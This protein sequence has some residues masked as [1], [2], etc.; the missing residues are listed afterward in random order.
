MSRDVSSESVY[1]LTDLCRRRW[2]IPI[3]G[4]LLLR[5]AGAE[6]YEI[7][8]CYADGVFH[9]VVIHKT[10][11]NGPDG[12]I[13]GVASV[14]LDVT[15]LNKSED[16]STMLLELTQAAIAETEVLYHLS[17]S[18]IVF[19]DLAGLLRAVVDGVADMLLANQVML[20]TVD[21]EQRKVIHFVKGGIGASGTAPGVSFDE[22]WNGLSGAVLRSLKPILST[23]SVPDPRESPEIQRQFGAERIGSVV[24]VPLRYQ[25]R[26][27]GTLAAVNRMEDPDF[28]QKM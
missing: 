9:D 28:T 5:G 24:V 17:S 8:L 25:E 7:P 12:R 3:P 18:L 20:T 6:V 2:W 1:D 21:L 15:E 22:L 11:L 26:T 27:L 16:K 19:D 4:L 23:K 14:L 10:T 13:V